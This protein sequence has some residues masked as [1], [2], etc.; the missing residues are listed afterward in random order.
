M[1]AIVDVGDA[2]ELTF[3]S[4][5]G[6]TV[7]A[8]WIAPGE[9]VVFDQEPVTEQPAGSGQFPFTFVPTGPDVWTA[10]FYSTGTATNAERYYIRALSV[11]GP[12]PYAV[13]GDIAEYLGT[14]T[15]AQ[16][17]LAASLLRRASDLVRDRFRDLD[18]RIAGGQLTANTA[19]QAV[20]N[21]VLRVMNNPRGL[22]SETTG[23][24]TRTWFDSG[25]AGSQLTVTAAEDAL[26][27][28][29]TPAKKAA[30]TIMARPGLAPAPLGFE[31]GTRDVPFW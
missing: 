12:P 8:S 25:A 26:L 31:R 16:E 6:A 2:V 1:S 15:A 21:M 29:G 3:S 13:I 20:T 22:R 28:R 27:S 18:T 7:T 24:F 17:N 5:P 10:W 9:V 14:L 23:P 11:N 4:A 30:R 19:A